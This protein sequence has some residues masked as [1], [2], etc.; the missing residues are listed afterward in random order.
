MF[1]KKHAKEES[2]VQELP[3]VMQM[4]EKNGL[5]ALQVARALHV[6]LPAKKAFSSAAGG[7]E[8]GKS[9]AGLLAKKK[10]QTV[11]LYNTCNC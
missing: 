1:R 4:E 3:P 10:V 7:T 11:V 2:N 8:V 5:A 6:R 9:I